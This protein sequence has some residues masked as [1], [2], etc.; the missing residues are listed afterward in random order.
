MNHDEVAI[1]DGHARFIG[2]AREGRYHAR[3]GCRAVRDYRIVLFVVLA[4]ILLNDRRIPVDKGPLE[5]LEHDFLIRFRH[6]YP[7]FVYL[8]IDRICGI[9]VN[10]CIYW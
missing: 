3:N 1:C 4:K 9:F 8:S 7:H 10:T 2:E 6:A 5:H